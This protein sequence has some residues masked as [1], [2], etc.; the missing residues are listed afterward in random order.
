MFDDDY[1]LSRIDE[2]CDDLE[3]DNL[4]S[5]RLRPLNIEG[6]RGRI[7]DLDNPLINVVGLAKLSE[8]TC[9]KTIR[10]VVERYSLEKKSFAWLVGPTS[11]PG[12]LVKYLRAQ[13]FKK[14]SDLSMSG[15]V[16]RN[17]EP[18]SDNDVRFPIRRV[19]WNE[20]GMN[21]DLIT[22]AFGFGMDE[23]VAKL[24]VELYI[25]SGENSSA[26]FAY[27]PET[28][29]P[30][31]FAAKVMDVSN[32]IVCLLGAG[33]LPEYRGKGIYQSL[34]LKRLKDA[35]EEGAHTAI[36]QA[37]KQTSAPICERMG[38]EVVC[39]IDF[40]LPDI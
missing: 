22:R 25:A 28:G 2:T 9:E 40:Y 13:G 11:K 4:P 31:A 15:L 19:N 26:Y 37:V 38:F 23:E 7:S 20:F 14:V 10:T 34:V 29:K 18:E 8:E 24:V 17:I 36:M 6:V 1:I 33:T 39:D 16:M 5:G 32:H 35:Y 21:L 27:D 3:I 12:S 30:V